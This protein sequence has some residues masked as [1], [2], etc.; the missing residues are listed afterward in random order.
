MERLRPELDGLFEKVFTRREDREINTAKEKIAGIY[1]L[2]HVSVT[3]L[4]SAEEVD[5]ALVNERQSRLAGELTS[6]IGRVMKASF[7]HNDSCSMLYEQYVSL[8]SHLANYP[9][10]F[11]T[12]AS[13]PQKTLAGYIEGCVDACCGNFA[14]PEQEKVS[15]S[16]PGTLTF[17]TKLA[18]AD[19]LQ[20][21]EE[22]VSAARRVNLGVA[23]GLALEVSSSL[24]GLR[25]MEESKLAMLSEPIKEAAEKVDRL[26]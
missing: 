8:V 26:S 21:I 19:T 23:E 14:V 20:R 6:I 10:Q 16:A 25:S 22:T 7:G 4:G 15:P 1:A 11:N 18:A 9:E 2:V 3:H 17:A 12:L 13:E 24:F 5:C